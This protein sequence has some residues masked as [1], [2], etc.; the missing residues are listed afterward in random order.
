MINYHYK[1]YLL[2]LNLFHWVN[3]ASS[4]TYGDSKKLPKVEDE[5]GRPLSP[6]AITKYVNADVFAKTYGAVH[7]TPLF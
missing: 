2:L 7:W 6:Y 1:I 5:I 4:S 3:A